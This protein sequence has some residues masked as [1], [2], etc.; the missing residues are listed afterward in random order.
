MRNLLLRC[1]TF[2]EIQRGAPGIQRSLLTQRLAILERHG[3]IGRHPS[4]SGRGARY[5]PTSAGKDLWAVCVA[6]GECGARWLELA[7]EHL[8]RYMA[9][10]SM[11]KSLAIDRLP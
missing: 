3:I 11:C 8:D 6:L 10:W 9:L 2:T 7:P 4:P 1:E 5:V